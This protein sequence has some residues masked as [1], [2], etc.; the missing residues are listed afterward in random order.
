MRTKSLS[1]RTFLGGGAA[2]GLSAY[3]TKAG[4]A[5]QAAGFNKLD[6]TSMKITKIET[7][8]L[9]LP[10][11]PFADGAD[12]TG[13]ESAPKK[14]LQAVPSKI[15]A[16]RDESG[17]KL[18]DYVLVK[19]HT[20]KGI[21]GMGDDCEDSET[22]QLQHSCAPFSRHRPRRASGTPPRCSPAGRPPGCCGPC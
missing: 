1:R 6:V 18:M 4:Y 5:A 20:D 21:I 10:V 19:V 11:K 3:T 9:S 15:A 14:Y 17:N 16:H 8:P 12:K 2:L 22:A 7:I 13:G